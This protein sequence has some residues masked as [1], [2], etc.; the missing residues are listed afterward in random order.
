MTKTLI[1]AAR[2]LERVVF[3]STVTI[4]HSGK[5]ALVTGSGRGIGK[6]IATT[7]ARAGADIVVV[8]M[9]LPSAERTAKEIS[10]TGRKAV[11]FRVDVSRKEEVEQVTERAVAEFGHVDILVNN[12]GTIV[13]KPMLE[14]TDDDWNRVLNVNLMGTY[15]FCRAVGKYMVAQKFGRIVNIGSIMGAFALP[16]RASYCASKG[17]IIMLTKELATEWAEHGITANA[18][19]P[20]WIETELTE[21][22]FAVA[23]NKKFLFERIPLKRFGQ[24]SDIANFVVFITSDLAHYVTG[25]SFFVD[26]GWITQ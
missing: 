18:V 6:A 20:G 1:S 16:P 21:K 10:A 25:Q 5:V 14:F 4:D 12:A 2:L 22:F 8:D 13:R 26:G 15:Y 17:G 23:E 7:F 11:A 3:L 19:S 24:P 9:D